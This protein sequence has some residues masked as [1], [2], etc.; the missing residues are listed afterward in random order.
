[1]LAIGRKI[2]LYEY[3]CQGSFAASSSPVV[4]R[5]ILWRPDVIIVVEPSLACVPSALLAARLCGAKAWLHIQ[6]F[7]LDAALDLG[8]L[9]GHRAQRPCTGSRSS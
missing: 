6:D 9:G 4:L 8:L 1:M 5:Q 3:R 2:N 7:E